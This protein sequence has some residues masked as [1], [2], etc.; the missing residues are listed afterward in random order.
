[1]R[2]EFTLFLTTFTTLLAIIN[3]LEALPVFLQLM[4]GKGNAEHRQVAFKSCF[5]ATLLC[6]FFLF[7]GVYLL[8]LFDVPMSM[9]RIAGGIVLTRIGFDLFAPSGSGGS[10]VAP[11]NPNANIAFMPLAIP[12]MFGPGAIATILGMTATVRQS[13][14]EMLSYAAI[15]GAILATM[16]ITFLCLA[17]AATLAKR[18]GATGI[19]AATRIVGFFVSA[20]G[21][22]LVFDGVIE[23]LQVHG[24]KML[25]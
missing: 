14:H 24:V 10:I 25:H 6:L 11:S 23:A 19:D 13:H 8:K 9:I 12:L 7:F 17:F 20:I 5:Y 2:T 21:V 1:M 15:A 4:E 3:P 18:L 22:S 16:L